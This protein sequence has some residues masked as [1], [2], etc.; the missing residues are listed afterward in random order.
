M[1]FTTTNITLPTGST[2][3]LIDIAINNSKGVVVGA[4]ISFADKTK[5]PAALV[6][7]TLKDSN[8][9]D[10]I[11]ALDVK[12]YERRSGG[13]TIGS[14]ISPLRIEDKVLEFKLTTD[15]APAVDVVMDLVLT[16]ERKDCPNV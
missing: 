11:S 2:S 16:H 13:T 5:L 6:R 4:F 1:E 14:M 9:N 12:E 7:G 3:E 15:T 10:L 8:G